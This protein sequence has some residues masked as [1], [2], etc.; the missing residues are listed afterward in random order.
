MFVCRIKVEILQVPTLL[1]TKLICQLSEYYLRAL[2]AFSFLQ[3]ILGTLDILHS[4]YSLSFSQV[5]SGGCVQ[6]LY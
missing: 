1:M 5:F 4:F 3:R 2:V 6:N